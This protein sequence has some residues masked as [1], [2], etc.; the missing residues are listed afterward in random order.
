M[1]LRR[2]VG[3]LQRRRPDL[4]GAPVTSGVLRS[5]LPVLDRVCSGEHRRRRGGQGRCLVHE[6]Q[7]ALEGRLC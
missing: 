6:D 3:A 5:R 4:E 7:A 2:D 1:L